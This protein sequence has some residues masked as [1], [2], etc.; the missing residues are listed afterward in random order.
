MGKWETN[1]AIGAADAASETDEDDG[2]VFLDAISNVYGEDSSAAS[3]PGGG[4][5]TQIL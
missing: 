4:I 3:M 5:G 2:D 1:L